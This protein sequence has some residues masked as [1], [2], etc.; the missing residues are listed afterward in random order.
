MGKLSPLFAGYQ[1]QDSQELMNFVLDGL[2]EDLN[3]VEE[4]PYVDLM[5]DDKSKMDEVYIHL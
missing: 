2:H 5:E 4:K 3:L 1:Q